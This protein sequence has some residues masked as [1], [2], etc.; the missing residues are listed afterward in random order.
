[1]TTTANSVTATEGTA[2]HPALEAAATA[3]RRALVDALAR[4]DRPALAEAVRMGA[5]ATPTMRI[6]DLV[7]TAILE[8]VAPHRVNVL[9]EE[10]GFVDV[11]SAV[12]LVI[13][14]LDGSANAAAGVPLSCFTG[15]VAVDG[16]ARQALTV[17]LETGRRWSAR[18]DEP[19]PW[20]TSGRTV[21]DGAAISLLRPHARNRDAWW[22]VTER[23]ERIRILSCSALE[24]VLVAEGATDAFADAG[25]DTHRLVDLV[26]ALVL[27]PPAGGA[28]VDARGRP[29][30]IHSD[31]T[32]RY[33]GVVAASP[34]LTDALCEAITG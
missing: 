29:I 9:S 8:A 1:M 34:A 27:V 21:L 14:P 3:A 5:D 30:Q 33:S 24:S 31:L 15:A 4:F 13:D 2:L 20:R 18:V 32:R 11:G 16:E 10:A 12:T 6:D 25:S 28:V 7:E 26:A 22:R 19:V 17:W 23:A